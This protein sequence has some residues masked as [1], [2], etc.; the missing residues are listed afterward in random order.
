M[1]N[2]VEKIK[3]ILRKLDEDKES[4][5]KS[6]KNVSFTETFST[7]DNV[8]DTVNIWS[9]FYKWWILPWIYVIFRKFRGNESL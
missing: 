5:N 1:Q 7:R 8:H 3:G 9:Q 6:K 4:E 2:N